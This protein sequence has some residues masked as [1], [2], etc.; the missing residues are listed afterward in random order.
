[1]MEYYSSMKSKEILIHATAWMYFK[2]LS[3]NIMLSQ[4]QK[5]TYNSISMKWPEQADLQRQKGDQWLPEAEGNQEKGWRLATNGYRVSFLD[6]ECVLNLGL[7]YSD[8]KAKR[9]GF[10]CFQTWSLQK[11]YEINHVLSS[12]RVGNLYVCQGKE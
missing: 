12:E 5:S 3:E 7:R 4:L 2:N 6:D 9:T 11:K 10:Y 1:M 8:G